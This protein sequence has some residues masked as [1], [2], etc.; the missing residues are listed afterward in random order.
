MTFSKHSSPRLIGAFAFVS[1]ATLLVVLSPAAVSATCCPVSAGSSAGTCCGATVTSVSEAISSPA[2]GTIR[3]VLNFTWSFCTSGSCS[4]NARTVRVCTSVVD[5]D[6]ANCPA[7]AGVNCQDVMVSN[8]TNPAVTFDFT[9][10]T[11]GTN[12]TCHATANDIS[13]G[14]CGGCSC[15][16]NGAVCGAC[17]VASANSSC[18]TCS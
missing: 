16:F 6:S 10:L 12:Y 4:C 14:G 9:P 7:V 3:C 11:T 5:Q 1:L 2:S 18:F 13:A 17:A 15:P 8:G